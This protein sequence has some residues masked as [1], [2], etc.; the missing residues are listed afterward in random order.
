MKFYTQKALAGD[1][2]E[3]FLCVCR[4]SR[5]TVERRTSNDVKLKIENGKLKIENGKLKVES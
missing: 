3:G 2:C 1:S 4:N 5:P